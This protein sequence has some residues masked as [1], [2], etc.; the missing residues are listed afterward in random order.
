VELFFLW[1]VVGLA[2]LFGLWLVW[3]RFGLP[4]SIAWRAL[5]S[6]ER[7]AA[8][9]RRAPIADL[10]SEVRDAL[11]GERWEQMGPA[12]ALLGEDRWTDDRLLRA[13]D[14]LFAAL[15]ADDESKGRSG[16]DSNYF[17]FHDCGLAAI[18]EALQKRRA[19]ADT[20]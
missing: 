8:R 10:L 14:E 5:R 18:C 3:E 19:D 9:L 4:G 20:A 16:R 11:R 7:N 1:F 13:L 17:E 12:P 15:R 2:G 6:T